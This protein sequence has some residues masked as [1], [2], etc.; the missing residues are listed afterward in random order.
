MVI[1][2]EWVKKIGEKI[3]FWAKTEASGSFQSSEPKQLH[4]I[5]S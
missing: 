2:I 5:N 3:D 4:R 1:E